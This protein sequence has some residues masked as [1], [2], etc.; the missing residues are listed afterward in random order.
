MKVEVR[1]SGYVCGD[2]EWTKIQILIQQ[3]T[4]WL[5]AHSLIHTGGMYCTY[6]K[7]VRVTLH[8]WLSF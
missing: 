4:M 3:T 5:L 2:Q 1:K 7:W 8:N 6:R